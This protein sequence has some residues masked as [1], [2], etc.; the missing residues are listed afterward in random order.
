MA[1]IFEKQRPAKPHALIVDDSQIARYV[2]SDMLERFGLEVE[3]ADSAEIGL[4]KI[5]ESGSTD[6]FD[7]VFMDYLLPGIDGLEAVR[8]LRSREA[9]MSL[10]IVMYT[11][12]D[13]LEFRNRAGDAGANDIFVKTARQDALAVILKRLGITVT[14]SAGTPREGNVIPMHGSPTARATD[15]GGVKLLARALEAHHAALRSDLLAEFAILERHEEKMRADLAARVNL[16]A[17]HMVTQF[18]QSAN[19][20]SDELAA[21]RRSAAR[22]GWA[23]AALFALAM[24]LALGLAWHAGESN[25]AVESR[26]S[27]TAAALEAQ[28]RTI[29]GLREELRAD[30]VASASAPAASEPAELTPAAA[31]SQRVTAP[32]SAAAALVGEIQSMGIMGRIRIQTDAGA[33]CVGTARDG[34]R[35]EGG[36]LAFSECEPLPIAPQTTP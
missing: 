11:S 23:Q 4:Q 5:R 17:R 21:E 7:V 6:R 24:S 35:I 27:A 20:S 31:E 13:S 15:T 34:Y 12:E 28:S 14:H 10:P 32:P 26:L 18:R 9:T 16:L 25:T 30:A 22:R 1:M 2:L 33:F 3:V 8:R 29:E 19:V 36:N